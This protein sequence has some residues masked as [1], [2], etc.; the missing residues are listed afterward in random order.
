MTDSFQKI[1]TLEELL[2][3][4]GARP[5][6][7]TALRS[8][9]LIVSAL[10]QVINAS[11]TSDISRASAID[12]L[13]LS[14]VTQSILLRNNLRTVGD[15]C[16]QTEETLLGVELIGSGRVYEIKKALQVH[17]LFLKEIP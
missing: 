7:I 5:E 14:R 12:A 16:R 4:A 9:T 11:A 3:S 10:A 8:N 2:I 15:L 1:A 6:A 17:N 13:R